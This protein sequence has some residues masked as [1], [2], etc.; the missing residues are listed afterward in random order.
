M[1]NLLTEAMTDPERDGTQ[2]FVVFRLGGEGYALEV[3]RVQEVLD[4][5]SM[6][7][8]PGS[9]RALLGV[10][11]LRGHVVPVYDLRI[12][13]GL[14]QDKV[15]NRAPSVLIVETEVGN[16]AQVT[17]LVVD[18][19]SD[20]LEFTPEEI[21]PAPQ[22]GLGKTT[23]FVRGLIRHQERFLLV[24]DVDRVFAALASLNGGGA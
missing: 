8:V 9:P 21:Q 7:E 2:S 15:P 3:M 10:I 5:Q 12:P 6:T 24:L 19:V 16:D 13:F 23:P 17:G 1:V 14:A 18:R 11:N 4:V 20:V 22:L